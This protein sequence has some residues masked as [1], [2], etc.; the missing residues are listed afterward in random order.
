MLGITLRPLYE[1]ALPRASVLAACFSGYEELVAGGPPDGGLVTLMHVLQ[2]RWVYVM[3][4]CLVV[5]GGG[6]VPA[7]AWTPASAGRRRRVWMRAEAPHLRLCRVD[8]VLGAWPGL[9]KLWESRPGHCLVLSHTGEDDHAEVLLRLAVRL[10]GQ[11][12]EVRARP[13]WGR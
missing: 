4:L 13:D 8:N 5:T 11:F 9:F 12:A 3:V 2:L 1:A 7:S 6:L 10:Q